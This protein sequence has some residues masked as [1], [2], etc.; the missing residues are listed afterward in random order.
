MIILVY[1][2]EYS[3]ENISISNKVMTNVSIVESWL[4]VL[5]KSL[6]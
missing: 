2:W 3:N 6:S 1:K 4:L 5:K